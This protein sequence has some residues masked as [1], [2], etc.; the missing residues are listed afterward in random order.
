MALLKLGITILALVMGSLGVL[1][2]GVVSWSAL[3][4]GEI[5][6]HASTTGGPTTVSTVSRAR[7]PDRFWRTFALLGPL[8]LVLGAVVAAAA[9]RR[10]TS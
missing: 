7:E 10:L 1:T 9:W 4:E 8:P 6:M 3:R 2:G 5:T